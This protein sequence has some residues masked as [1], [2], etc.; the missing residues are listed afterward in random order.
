[1]TGWLMKVQQ[2][3]KRDLPEETIVLGESPSAILYIKNPT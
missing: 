1:M 2:L 3:M